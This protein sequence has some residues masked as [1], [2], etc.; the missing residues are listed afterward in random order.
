MTRA[1]GFTG[2]LVASLTVG[3]FAQAETM[4]SSA[5]AAQ[6][7]SSTFPAPREVLQEGLN[8]SIGIMAGVVNPEGSYRTGAEYGFSASVQ[9]YIPFG[10]GMQITFSKNQSK[11]A[12][13]RDLDRTTAMIRG[14]YNF[15][16]TMT[17]IKNSYVGMMTGPVI[18]QDATY[19]GLA[20]V[21]GFDIPVREWSGKYLSYLSVGAEAKYMI[22]SSNESD[23]LTVN[24]VLKYWF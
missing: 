21:V 20:P 15:G 1:F 11:E 2:L 13:T 5:P 14:T 10:L 4:N 16:G 24:G 19:F 6:T 18:N 3:V 23:G 8:P 12:N 22:V 9:P 7:S 17:V